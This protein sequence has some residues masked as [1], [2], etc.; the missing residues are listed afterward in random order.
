MK[1]YTIAFLF[2]VQLAGAQISVPFNDSQWHFSNNNHTAEDY[3]GKPSVLLK[4][5]QAWLSGADFE[6]GIIEYD[7]AVPQDRV[8]AGVQFRAQD[9]RNYEEFY[10]RAHQSGNPDANQYS[11]VFSGLSAWQLYYGDG[12]A[13]PVKYTFDSWMHI[14]LLILG[15]Q[16]EVYIDNME[17]PVLFCVLKRPVKRGFLGIQSFPMGGHFANF[18]Y[19]STKDVTLKNKPPQSPAI[20]KGTILQWQVSSALPEKT[21]E[22]VTTLSPAIKNGLTWQSAAAE[23]TGTV[24]LASVTQG[25]ADNNTTFAKVIIQSDRDQI[26]KIDFG[27]SDRVKI[28]LNDNILFSGQ[29]GFSSRDYRFLGTIGYYDAVYLNLKKG[30][31]ELW[32]AISESFGGWGIKGKIEDQ[33]A[34]A[35][36]K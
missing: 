6:N 16:M 28:Y 31:N 32:F 20:V 14:K 13:A 3:L 2:I 24:N 17:T 18:T 21:L 26:K 4:G 27:F 30:R 35:I 7:V 23:I 33:E 25:S 12:Y 29:D 22:N 15:D 10:I 9:E 19:T 36:V 34:I 5:C 11:P 8:F 1:N